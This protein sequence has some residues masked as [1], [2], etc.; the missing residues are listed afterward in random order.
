MTSLLGSHAGCPGRRTY[1]CSRRMLSRFVPDASGDGVYLRA[2]SWL[3]LG[4]VKDI[5]DASGF[6]AKRRHRI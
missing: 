5:R 1:S 2:I 3:F 6:S 4:G